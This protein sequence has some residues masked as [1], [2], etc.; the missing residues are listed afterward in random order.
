M[1]DIEFQNSGQLMSDPVCKRAVGGTGLMKRGA[2][3]PA[4]RGPP[5]FG[6]TAEGEAGLI[7]ADGAPIGAEVGVEVEEGL[8]RGTR[9][10]T[11]VIGAVGV[12]G[13]LVPI[14]MMIAAMVENW[15]PDHS[16]PMQDRYTEMWNEKIAADTVLHAPCATSTTAMYDALSTTA[17]VT[18]SSS[19]PSIT[20]SVGG[21]YQNSTTAG[22]LTTVTLANATVIGTMLH[23]DSTAT[24]TMSTVTKTGDA[25]PSA[26]STDLPPCHDYGIDPSDAEYRM[27]YM[28]GLRCP[29][30]LAYE[31]TIDWYHEHVNELPEGTRN[32]NYCT[33]G[34]VTGHFRAKEM[35]CM[36]EFKKSF[37]SKECKKEFAMR[38]LSYEDWMKMRQDLPID[39]EVK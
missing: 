13:A 34:D 20:N 24:P 17:S 15:T 21:A 4:Q 26:T 11:Q 37:G 2:C 35:G 25:I 9:M 31:C 23:A 32:P 29:V 3:S 28:R 36:K 7:G 30:P 14:A 1:E 8:G 5:R 10:V 39:G 27:V 19:M 6:V 18:T 16:C 33:N 38:K 12:V 22:S